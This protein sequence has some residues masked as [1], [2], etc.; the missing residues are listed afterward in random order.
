MSWWTNVKARKQELANVERLLNLQMA[1][2]RACHIE[3][4]KIHDM[5]RP[6]YRLTWFKM[7]TFWNDFIETKNSIRGKNNIFWILTGKRVFSPI[8][9]LKSL[10]AWFES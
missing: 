5:K 6:S 7:L 9:Y 2:L 10:I 3:L 4:D 8:Y 1:R